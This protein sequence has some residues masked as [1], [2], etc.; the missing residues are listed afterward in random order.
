MAGIKEYLEYF[1][2][3]A[4]HWII[5]GYDDS[6][7]NYPTATH[8]VRI[9][10]KYISSLNK[11]GLK[12][13]DL[14]CGGGNLAFRLAGD[15]HNV[16]GIDQSRKMIEIAENSLKKLPKKLRARVQFLRREIG[17]KMMPDKKFDVVTAMG[18]IGY[19]PDDRILFKIAGDLLKPNGYLLVSVRNRLFNMKSISFRTEKEI[20]NK[21]A[22]KL[23]KELGG[24][25]NQVSLKDA[26]RFVRNLKEA[27]SGFSENTAFDKKSARSPL[28]KHG[29]ITPILKSEP[30]QSTP[31]ELKKAASKCGFKYKAYYGVHPHLLDP[32]LNKMLPP[33][34]FNKISD[35][36]GAFEHLPMSLAWSS[37]FMGV[38]QKNTKNNI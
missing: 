23:I 32:A 10:S 17:R 15:G 38:F 21:N 29:L 13:A 24:L 1:E 31:E 4:R 30:R 6:A 34:L 36:L 8:R 26:N 12:I 16:L 11:K 7:Y 9:V 19:L 22:L 14:G 33:Q 2:N 28:E 25:Y 3:N 35:C 27:V 5:G 18:L 37:V 20:K